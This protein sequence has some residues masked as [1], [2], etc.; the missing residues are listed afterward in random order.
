MISKLLLCLG[1]TASFSASAAIGNSVFTCNFDQGHGTPTAVASGG[2]T[3][4]CNPT[5]RAKFEADL[6]R[7][8]QD[9]EI[10]EEWVTHTSEPG[11]PLTYRLSDSLAKTSTVHL[12]QHP[13]LEIREAIIHLPVA[14]G[15]SR[16]VLTVSQKEIVLALLH[17]SRKTAA[18]CDIQALKD[19]VGIRQNTV[20]WAERLEWQWPDGTPAQWNKKHWNRG[21]PVGDLVAAVNDAFLQQKK[22][23]IGC[24]TA[25]KL[26]VTQ[27]VLDY[28]ARIRPDAERLSAIVQELYRDKDPLVN[29]EPPAM[30]SFE[31]DFNPADLSTSGKLL[32]LNHDVSPENFIP[33]DWA[34][35][36]NTDTGTNEKTGYEGSNAIYLGRGKFDDYYNDHNY[37]YGYQEKLDEVYQWR[38]HVFSRSRDMGKVSPLTVNEV[39]R[40][41]ATPDKGGLVL[42]YR[43]VPY[44]FGQEN[45]N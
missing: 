12:S 31:D 39:Y 33:G 42:P 20:A 9:L 13:E 6:A 36:R 10:K 24:Y 29:I 30:W 2:L 1:L 21:T 4:K 35:L 26:V 45:L 23:A 27:G 25:S 3:F 8:L 43:A 5:E 32:K 17:P 38:N 16:A 11:E 7:Y 34:Y 40:L 15:A 28:Y 41:G 22:Y 44:F 37:N 19:H 14:N 18:P